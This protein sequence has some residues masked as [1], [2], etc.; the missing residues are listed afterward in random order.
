MR[1]P[2]RVPFHA[3]MSSGDRGG[4]IAD[5]EGTASVSSA[6]EVDRSDLQPRL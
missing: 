1:V 5:N 3:R 4:Q 2:N 6:G